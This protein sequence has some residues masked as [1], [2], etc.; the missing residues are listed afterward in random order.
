VLSQEVEVM[1]TRIVGEPADEEVYQLARRVAEAQIDLQR[2]RSAQHQILS[3]LASAQ[4]TASANQQ[5]TRSLPQRAPGKLARILAWEE[6]L[7]A[8]DRYERRALSRRRHAIRE[9]D[10]ARISIEPLWRNEAKK[11]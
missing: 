4:E 9:L 2:V 10:E 11:R 3:S 8:M 5:Y 1:A 6:T 7:R